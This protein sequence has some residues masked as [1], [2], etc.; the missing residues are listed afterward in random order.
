LALLAILLKVLY[1]FVAMVVF[2]GI[3]PKIDDKTKNV[4]SLIFGF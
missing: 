4:L 2:T 3:N 1:D